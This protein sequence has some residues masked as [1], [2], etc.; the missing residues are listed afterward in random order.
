M[1]ISNIIPLLVSN[2]QPIF[3][4][5]DSSKAF[6]WRIR[7]LPYPLNVY[8]VSVNEE[9]E[10]I[11]IRTSNKKYV[12][13]YTERSLILLLKGKSLSTASLLSLFYLDH[14]YNSFANYCYCTCKG[15]QGC[16]S[17]SC[18]W[19]YLSVSPGISSFL[20]FIRYSSEFDPLY[21]N[22][23]YFKKFN[24]PDMERAELK[25]EQS[26]ISIAH[27]NNTLIISVSCIKLL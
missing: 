1:F 2:P 4:R 3:T 23:R 9:K 26:A 5:K 22:F 14:H 19:G 18:T 24:I 8:S 12:N 7:N 17:K 27:A 21:F 13:F 25:L 20:A 10:S 11:T 16:I 15:N 6:Q